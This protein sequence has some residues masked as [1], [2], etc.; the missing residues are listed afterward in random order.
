MTSL[1]PL[2]LELS[3]LKGLVADVV[4]RLA[5]IEAKQASSATDVAAMRL[6]VEGKV[7]RDTLLRELAGE[8]GLGGSTWASATAI[9]LILSGIRPPPPGA[10]PTVAALAVT[11]LSVRQVWRILKAGVEAE[12]ADRSRAL[13]QWWSTRDDGGTT[14]DEDHP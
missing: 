8:L 11:R 6:H 4:E 1:E 14:T 10:E 5:R 13:C 3:L 12:T 2:L 7:R 9:S